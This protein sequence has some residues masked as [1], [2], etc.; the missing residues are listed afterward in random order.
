M[1]TILAV[2]SMSLVTPSD[3]LVTEKLAEYAK[4]ADGAFAANTIN[5][6]ASDTAH[7]SAW[8]HSHG[9]TA[10]PTTAQTLADYIRDMMGSYAPATIRRR[11]A[12]IAHMHRAAGLADATKEDKV[13]LALRRMARMKRNRQKQA[14]PITENDVSAILATT[15]N[16]LIDLRDKVLLL[17]ARD[18]LARRSELTAIRIQDISFQDDGAATVLIGRSKTD[19]EGDGVHMWI[20]QRTASAIQKWLVASN[21]NDGYLLRSVRRGGHTIGKKL[22]DRCASERF[23][24][25]AERAGITSDNISGHSARIGMAQD[26]AAAGADL[27]ELMTAGRWKSPKMPAR[28][29]ERTVAARGAVAKYHEQRR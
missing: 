15:G 27:P 11:M 3:T 26:L 22:S 13:K 20:S 21:I 23:K 25:M 10:L 16:S 5:A 8:C 9:A 19:Q 17:M 7:F 29:I 14:S 18:M 2:K 4:N 12:S 24:L 28:Y 1:T 6:I